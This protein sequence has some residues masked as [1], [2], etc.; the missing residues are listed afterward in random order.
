MQTCTRCGESKEEAEFGFRSAADGKRH[1]WCKVCVAEYARE[2]Y[3]RNPRCV[4][5]A[6]CCK[7]A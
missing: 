7:H 4:H 3:A 1:R 6:E 5:H 2:H